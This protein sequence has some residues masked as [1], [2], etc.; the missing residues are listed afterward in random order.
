[1]G[2]GNV[3]SFTGISQVTKHVLG[4]SIP[5]CPREKVIKIH[6]SSSEQ[7]HAYGQPIIVGKRVIVNERKREKESLGHTMTLLEKEIR[8]FSEFCKLRNFCQC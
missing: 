5:E 4:V 1:M 2:S 6:T 7:S 3:R 8:L